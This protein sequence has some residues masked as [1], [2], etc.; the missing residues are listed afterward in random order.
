VDESLAGQI[1]QGQRTVWDAG[2]FGVVARLIPSVGEE[3][4]ERTSVS[5]D[6]DVLDVACGT[7][8][9]ALPAARKRARVTGL[10]LVPKLLDQGRS[11]ADAEGLEVTWVEGD[12]EQ[13]PFE[14][15]SFDVVLSTFGCMFAPRHEVAAA[16]IARVLR[17]GGRL[18]IC[19]WTPDGAIGDFFK[20]I[21][22]H[23]PPPPE[24]VQPPPLWGREDHVRSLFDGTGVQPEFEPETVSMTFDSPEHALD[25]YETK[26]GPI[27]MAKAALEPQGKWQPLA[28]D[29]LAFFRGAGE[30]REE[31]TSLRAEYLAVTGGRPAVTP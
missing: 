21:A 28:D 25:M 4:V 26:F 6:D 17:P 11:A 1:K 24:G 19:S 22:S 10:D 9:A 27:V 3:I 14:D 15:Q 16:E 20:I 30:Q 5:P 7:G 23:M 18:G 31:R 8:N 12:A 29:L 2:D 13:L